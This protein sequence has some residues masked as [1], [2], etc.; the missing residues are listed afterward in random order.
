ME[1]NIELCQR[2]WQ[3]VMLPEHDNCPEMPIAWFVLS[4]F[5][6]GCEHR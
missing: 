5:A 6:V 4:I 1:L 2:C 3:G